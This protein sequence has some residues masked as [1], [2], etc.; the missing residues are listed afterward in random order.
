MRKN[1]KSTISKSGIDNRGSKMVYT[2]L[3]WLIIG[4]SAFVWGFSILFLLSR[5]NHYCTE[6]LDMMIMIGLCALTVYAQI[7]SLFYKVEKIALAGVFVVDI[8]LLICFYKELFSWFGGL[9]QHI[10]FQVLLAAAIGAVLLIATSGKIGVYDTSLYQAQSIR[11]VEEYGVVPGLGNLHS[12]LAYNS[13]FFC[14]Q[15]L[16][17]FRFWAGQSLH[18]MNGFVAWVMLAYAVCKMKYWQNRK[19]CAS[20]FL[21]LAII[22]Y[23]ARRMMEVSSPTT[24]LF[25]IG[26][27]GYIVSKWVTLLE[28]HEEKIAPYAYLCILG[29][30]AITLKLSAAMIILLVIVPAYQLIKGKKWEEVMLY[31]CVG[32]LTISPFLI[33]NII[34]SG[35]LLY[36]YPALD[37]FSVD[38]KMPA[39]VAM[40]EQVVIKTWAQGIRDSQYVDATFKEWFPLWKD[41]VCSSDWKMYILFWIDLTAI[42]IA[43]IIGV[44]RGWRR[45]EW[46]FLHVSFCLIAGI[47]FWF[48]S[49]PSIRFGETYLLLLPL[50]VMGSVLEKYR[51]KMVVVIVARAVFVLLGIYCVTKQMMSTVSLVDRAYLYVC[52][53]YDTFDCSLERIGEL[54]VYIPQNGSNQCGYYAFPSTPYKEN[55]ANI[56]LRG[57]SFAEGFREKQ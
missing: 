48:S 4:G 53:D 49:A 37:W 26:L 14:L 18:S 47:L 16:F 42:P 15:A 44:V 50:Y 56:E 38:W 39:T 31:I 30:Y 19:V 3:S 21:R 29:L 10:L 46:D 28:D 45:K 7:F 51:E 40:N 1:R 24:D 9:K 22:Y 36:P 2:L 13:S 41:M 17:S 27:V 35:Y 55:L 8:I 54:Y 52:A 25:A 34:L 57:E 33:R 6:T 43:I 20:D 11:W 5:V 32:I 23:Y 12:R